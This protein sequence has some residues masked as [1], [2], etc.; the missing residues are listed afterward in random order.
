M[1]IIDGNGKPKKLHHSK[2]DA[3]N[4]N[5]R[6]IA[7]TQP[8]PP[9]PRCLRILSRI[10]LLFEVV[11][12][13]TGREYKWIICFIVTPIINK[14]GGPLRSLTLSVFGDPAAIGFIRQAGSFAYPL[15]SWGCFHSQRLKLVLYGT[16]VNTLQ[17]NGN[18]S[19]MSGIFKFICLLDHL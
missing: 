1:P 5:L 15:F 13:S 6:P 14:H 19:I 10:T 17:T 9:M 11:L 7:V 3:E 18:F 8:L 2:A 4:R 12:L 16:A